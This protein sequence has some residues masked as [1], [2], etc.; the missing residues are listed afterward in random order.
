MGQ[1]RP[2]TA[3][4][5]HANVTDP[6]IRQGVADGPF[7]SRQRSVENIMKAPRRLI[8]LRR[9]SRF[10]WQT[11]LFAFAAMLPT[12]S[13]GAP[14]GPPKLNVGPSCEAAVQ[15]AVVIGRDK[16][17]CLGD[18]RTAQDQ[19]VKNW[20]Q[21]NRAD[22]TQCVGMVTT[23]GPPSYV[24]LQSCLEMMRDVKTIH[25]DDP[26]LDVGHYKGEL[27]TRSSN[28]DDLFTVDQPKVRRGQ[29]RNRQ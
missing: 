17:A 26:L 28:Q 1:N 16:E 2:P 29:K 13:I 18:E 23:G 25:K 27:N 19:I 5:E 21:Y 20:S 10:V 14:D 3:L 7:K 11:L 24:E 6:D 15:N 8:H 12:A 22:K 4:E 9:H